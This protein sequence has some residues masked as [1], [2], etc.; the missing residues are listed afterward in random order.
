M[1]RKILT[2]VF[3]GLTL[4]VVIGVAWWRAEATR[5]QVSAIV[6]ILPDLAG[7]PTPL[8]DRLL[9]ADA[10]ARGLLH[11]SQ[12]LVELSRLY[13]ANGFPDEAARCYRGLSQ[14]D[15]ENPRWLHLLAGIQAGYGEMEPALALWSRVRKLAPEY[16]PAWLR[17]GDSL[18][19][20]NRREE[21]AAMYEGALRL[22]PDNPYAQWGLAR[23]DFEAGRWEQARSRLEGVVAK[24]HYTL[25]YDLI[26]TLYERLGLTDRAAAIR[27][28]GKASGAYRD[29]PD[30]WLDEL[31]EDCLEPYRLSLTAGMLAR[32]GDSASALRLLQRAVSVDPD[33]VAVRFQL[34]SLLQQQNQL[35]AAL[36][37]FEECTRLAPEFPDGWANLSALLAQQDRQ[38]AAER[39]LVDGL[40]HCPDSPGLHL[41]RAR[42][43]RSAGRTSEAIA[44]YRESIRLRPNEGDTGVELGMFYISLGRNDEAISAVS[45]ALEAEPGHPLAM[46]ILAFNAITSG[47]EADARAWLA[48]VRAQP[49]VEAAQLN[50]LVATY[51]KRFGVA[52]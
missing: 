27:A 19:K 17:S 2:P 8:R 15:P 50:R 7:L 13:H 48:R 20:A 30:P 11:A 34:G 45:H 51:Q 16:V 42:T 24:T 35:A 33:D 37:E 29:P 47:S 6:P 38:S 39:A 31:I 4:I 26:V 36:Q 52:P 14:L 41:M 28:R 23:L 43:H 32:T 18:L 46:F 40:R 9:S 1:S 25:G 10:R 44:E 49:R 22:E 3:V 5:R 12:G 21:A